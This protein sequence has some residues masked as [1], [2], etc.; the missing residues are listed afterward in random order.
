M[1]SPLRLAVDVTAVPARPAGAGHYTV[2]LVEALDRREDVALTLWCRHGDDGRWLLVA[3]GAKVL[4]ASPSPRPVRLMWEQAAL[5]LL[6]RRHPVDV[7]HSPHY[8]MP[9]LT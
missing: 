7:H 8:T 2:A 5:P 6:L 3:P 1:T 4:A 9:Q